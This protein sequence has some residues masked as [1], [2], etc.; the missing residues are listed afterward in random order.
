MFPA[1][2]QSQTKIKSHAS[3]AFRENRKTNSMDNNMTSFEMK[4]TVTTN[5]YLTKKKR[6]KNEKKDFRL[7]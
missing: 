6:E 7:T 2:F 1:L 3:Q 5:M 4:L